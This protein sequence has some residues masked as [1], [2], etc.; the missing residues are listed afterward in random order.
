MTTQSSPFSV[1]ALAAG[2]ASH[3]HG[4]GSCTLTMRQPRVLLGQEMPHALFMSGI[5]GVEGQPRNCARPP[6]IVG[7]AGTITLTY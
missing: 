2:S 4:A 1:E 5:A 7:V 6:E 3:A